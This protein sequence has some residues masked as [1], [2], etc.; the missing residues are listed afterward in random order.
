[1]LKL[2]L[3]LVGEGISPKLIFL[4]DDAADEDVVAATIP[5]TAVILLVLLECSRRFDGQCVLCYRVQHTFH[6]R[7]W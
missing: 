5:T 6:Q 7:C 1:M 4:L 2:K 3:T